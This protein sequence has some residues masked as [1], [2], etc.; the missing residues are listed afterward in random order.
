MNCKAFE[1]KINCL[2]E[3]KLLLFP[4]YAAIRYATALR[5][6]ALQAALH[7]ACACSRG[8]L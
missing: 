2:R 4:F 5:L 1:M 3:P 8:L 7:L 6:L